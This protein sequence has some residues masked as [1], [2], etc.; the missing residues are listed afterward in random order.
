MDQLVSLY[1]KFKGTHLTA[2]NYIVLSKLRDVLSRY[3]AFEVILKRD[4]LA[5]DMQTA[6]ADELLHYGAQV[7][8][9]QL[10]DLQLPQ[11]FT[12]AIEKTVIAEQN[13][14]KAI[15]ELN[16]AVISGETLRMTARIQA[17]LT[18]VTAESQAESTL[19]EANATAAGKKVRL[20]SEKNS[21]K[22]L[23]DQL[24]N[25]F[26]LFDKDDFISYVTAESVASSNA[27]SVKLAL[28]KKV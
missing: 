1:K 19:I 14:E 24:L 20:T 16:R 21:Y 2:F 17:N 22:A 13:V 5:S 23:L 15:F 12:H 9:L 7:T 4:T 26:T 18:E 3:T 11:D 25:D 8:A 28:D 6:V 27:G 10:G